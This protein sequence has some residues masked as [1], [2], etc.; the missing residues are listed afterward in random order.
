M[1]HVTIQPTSSAGPHVELEGFF[2]PFFSLH[3]FI[4]TINQPLA[5]RQLASGH[6]CVLDQRISLL[7]LI[8]E[9]MVTRFLSDSVEFPTCI[10]D[11]SGAGR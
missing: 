2:S 4:R 6:I 1:H 5:T 7:K 3:T 9:G 11:D 8:F 10:D